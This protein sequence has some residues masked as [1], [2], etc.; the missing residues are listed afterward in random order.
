[1][2]S[3]LIISQK[4]QKNSYGS[5]IELLSPAKLNLY[6]NIVGKYPDGYHRLESIVERV[7]LFDQLS[8]KINANPNIVIRSNKKELESKENLCYKAARLIKKEFNLPFGF[9]IYLKKNIP[10]GSG[11]GGGSS[12]AAFTILGIKRLLSFQISQEKLY[13]IGQKIGSD[14]NFFLSGAK[15]AYLSGRGQIVKP[16]VSKMKLDHFIVWPQVSV[17]TKRVYKNSKAKLTRFFS[18]V[19]IMEYSFRNLDRSLLKKGVYNCLEKSAFNLYKKLK[20]V[21]SILNSKDMFSIMSGSG[22]AFFTIGLIN[23]KKIKRNI[24]K[25]W[26][27]H[28]VQTV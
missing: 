11:L 23:G 3:Q 10:I 12:N 9:D 20:E 27:V 14:V 4:K 2:D 24:P 28:K 19:N 8:I 13:K 21:K 5:K 16:L 25:S 26:L 18:N 7:S 22:G 15:F 17:S 6:L 1:M